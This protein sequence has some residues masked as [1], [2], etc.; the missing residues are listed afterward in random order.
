MYSAKC[1][2]SVDVALS[3]PSCVSDRMVGKKSISAKRGR[4]FVAGNPEQKVLHVHTIPQQQS[5]CLFLM[6]LGGGRKGRISR[7]GGG[8]K[9]ENHIRQADMT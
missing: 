5:V 2:Q 6:R 1:I 3:P 7:L 4:L 8:G 9:G